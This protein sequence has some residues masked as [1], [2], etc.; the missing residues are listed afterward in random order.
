MYDSALSPEISK[1]NVFINKLRCKLITLKDSILDFCALFFKK[2]RVWKLK[3]KIFLIRKIKGENYPFNLL[4]PALQDILKRRGIEVPTIIQVLAIP[5]I[6]SGKNVLLM[7]PTGSGKMEAAILPILSELKRMEA[8]IKGGHIYVLYITPLRALCT[9][10]YER[11]ASY[12]A[13]L[14]G[15]F[16]SVSVRH[17]DVPE[18]QKIIIA[19]NPPTIL[20]T[21]P[22]S[23]EVMLTSGSGPPIDKFRTLKWVIVDEV[24]E[25]MSNKRGLHLAVLLERLKRLAKIERLQ[26]IFISATIARPKDVAK[27]FGGS[28]G[29]VLILQDYTDRKSRVEIDFIDA[30]DEYDVAKRICE[31]VDIDQKGG[32]L[33]FV[34]T[35]ALCENLHGVIER[36]FKDKPIRVHHGS[37]SSNERRKIEEEFKKGTIKGIV[38]TRTLE[39]GIDIGTIR[40]IF[41]VE[42]PTFPAYLVQRIGRSAH[43]PGKVANGI[44]LCTNA[45]DLLETLTLI[46]MIIHGKLETPG[47]II[48][49]RDV[50]LRQILA[51]LYSQF[52]SDITLDEMIDIFRN[53]GFYREFSTE[54]FKELFDFLEKKSR[55]VGFIDRTPFLIHTAFEKLWM[56]KK[57][58]SRLQP[59]FYSFIPDRYMLKVMHNGQEIGKIDPLNLRFLRK[60][61]IIRLSGKNWM[62]ERI[63]GRRVEVSEVSAV[64]YRIPIWKGGYV[65]LTENVAWEFYKL[66]KR[67]IRAYKKMNSTEI[68]IK[69][70]LSSDFL[71]LELQRNAINAMESLLKEIIENRYELPDRT[72]L[73]VEKIDTDRKVTI[74]LYPFG[75]AIANTLAALYWKSGRVGVVIPK[76]YGLFVKCRDT[77]FDPVK[78]L[79]QSKISED[80]IYDAIKE[81]P[82]SLV[83]AFEICKNFG[84]GRSKRL[85]EN[86]LKGDNLF[87]REVLAQTID[88][89]FDIKG[90]LKFIEMLRCKCIKIKSYEAMYPKE[91]HTLSSVMFPLKSWS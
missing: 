70:I 4:H 32:Y 17:S 5:K 80:E 88:R 54:Y 25:L 19:Q 16:V 30:E 8:T 89:Y 59:S 62:V 38:C 84:Y 73:I 60:G 56:I 64:D 85:L 77:L 58:G 9:N 61:S 37:L 31:L 49:C 50:I 71:D 79:L 39:L 86:L 83:V 27:Y 18:S 26:R 1:F 75:D 22:E 52:S 7:G 21:T 76:A 3:A 87:S 46:R 20:V 67:L 53:V 69:K 28:D 36:H 13:E 12:A 42:S 2:L 51:M 65:L 43:K 23:L 81:S 41:Q 72:T 34:N 35:R 14:F 57:N 15:I 91:R 63:E 47:V 68:A 90:T 55:L 6:L 11:I 48:P 40:R 82:Y 33:I 24:H 78:F 66:L 45:V 29:D 10:I 74:L 44:I